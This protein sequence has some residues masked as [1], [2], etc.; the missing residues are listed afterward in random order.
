MILILYK[1]VYVTCFFLFL[2]LRSIESFLQKTHIS[3]S[4][5]NRVNFFNTNFTLFYSKQI[6][7][8]RA[9]K[10]ENKTRVLGNIV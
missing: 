4:D 3:R 7:K 1:S 6:E 8:R 9:N 10:I 2:Y 5:L